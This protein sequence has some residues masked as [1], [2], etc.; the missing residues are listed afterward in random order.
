MIHMLWAVPLA[1]LT[2]LAIGY[3]LALPGDDWGDDDD[4]FE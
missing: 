2:G 3:Y 4:P 1:L